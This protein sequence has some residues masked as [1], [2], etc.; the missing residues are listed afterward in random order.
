MGREADM[1]K[2]F[3][4][5]I[6]R[7]LAGEEVKVGAAID[8]DYRTAID[9]AQKMVRLRGV[10]S[11]SFKEQLKERLLL[12]LSEQETKAPAGA[13][14]GR[15]WGV[16]RRLV[17]RQPVWR[18]V[19]TTALVIIL[20]TVGVFWYMGGFTQAPAPAP[21]TPEKCGIPTPT[22]VP[23]PPPPLE[24]E[25]T[26]LSPVA[27]APAFSPGKEVKIL[28]VFKNVSSG[29]IT[30]APFP[31]RIEITRP[32]TDEVVRSFP[33]GSEQLDISP[34]ETEEYT[35]VWD[36][37]DNNG[38][39]VT[40][41]WYYVNVKVSF[42]RATEPTRG[43]GSLATMTKLLIQLPQGAMEKFIRV[44]QSQTVSGLT[45]TLE[46]VEL[47]AMGARFLAFTIP[48]G[49]SLPEQRPDLPSPPP[50]DWM[51][52]VHAQYTVDGVTKDAGNAG[53]R[54]LAN[55]VELAWGYHGAWL[56]PV[57]SDAKELIFTI[58]RFGDLEG[59]WQFFIPLEP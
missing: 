45:I 44:G 39:Q 27:Y 8:D 3:S 54:F 30:V 43:T 9:F 25:A 6:D 12:K 37:K 46:R 2:E 1:E 34:V 47:S 56:D 26:P 4:E 18:A 15:F 49:Y 31:P 53:V 38:R 13:K 20:A 5:N 50:P 28:F 23:A 17:P 58:T 35:L 57:P 42:S 41:G 59:P 29:P 33:G 10:P 19:T 21:L 55:S 52:P 22:P 51:V 14:R 24:I 36:Q 32:K 40:P 11:S 16:L 7:M 48:P